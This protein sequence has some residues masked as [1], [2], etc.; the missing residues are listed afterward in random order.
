MNH[1][2]IQNISVSNV[3]GEDFVYEDRSDGATATLS[4]FETVG[5]VDVRVTL[6]DGRITVVSFRPT[7]QQAEQMLAAAKTGEVWIAKMNEKIAK[8]LAPPTE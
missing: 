8:A 4:V 5:D 2:D 6:P 3:D 1:S 7:V